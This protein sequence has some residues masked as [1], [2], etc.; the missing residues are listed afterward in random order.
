MFDIEKDSSHE[1]SFEKPDSAVGHFKKKKQMKEYADKR[2]N[3]RESSFVVGDTVPLKQNKADT[4]TA[5]Y[6]PSPYSVIGVKGTIVTVK[7]EREIKA[8]NSSR[9]KVLKKNEYD[10]LDWDHM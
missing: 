3:A 1:G 8:R 10:M 5:A 2:R 6:D 9:C 7:R 4:L